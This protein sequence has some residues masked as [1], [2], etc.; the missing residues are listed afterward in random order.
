MQ[1]FYG[2]NQ[3]QMSDGLNNDTTLQATIITQKGPNN[4]HKKLSF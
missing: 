1:S 4:F 3:S 2:Q